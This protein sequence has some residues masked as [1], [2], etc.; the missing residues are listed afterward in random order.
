M[1]KIVLFVLIAAGMASCKTSEQK[2]PVETFGS[3]E[4]LDSAINEIIAKN[5]EIKIVG[6]GYKWSEGPVWVD[7]EKMLLFSDVPNNVIHKWTEAKGVEQY[8]TPSG[9]TGQGHYSNEPG[10]NGLTLSP[11]GRLVL[12]QH[13]DRRVAYMNAPWNNPAANFVTLADNY[14]GKKLSSPNDAT[15]RSNGDL[16]FTDPP[17]GLPKQ[18]EDPTKETPH[19]GV[20]KVSGGV[21]SLVVDS[22]TRPNGIAFLKGEKTL[23]VANSDPD[24]ARWYAFDLD[25]KD[26]VVSSR[27]FFDVTS[28]SKA[29]EPGL[30]DGLRVDSRGNIY[31]TGPGGIWIFDASGKVLGRIRIPEPT[32]NC[33]LTADEKT[34][35]ITANMYLV[36]VR[37]RD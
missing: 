34:L 36:K 31:A 8:L 25:D 16:F 29:G 21:T 26:S 1:R 33:A 14:Q 28:N 7:A 11:E 20:Y 18:A 37:L 22:L 9:Y 24:K 13:G 2:T 30:P 12:C 32:A 35:F 19:N 17:Y 27:I 4:R 10:S 23:L 15:F 5:A 3:I 6:Q